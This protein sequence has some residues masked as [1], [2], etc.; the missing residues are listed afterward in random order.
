MKV[1]RHKLPFTTETGYTFNE[2]DIAYDTWGTLN[3]S[4][5]NVIWVCH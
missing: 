3:E 5:D 2:L 4:G 1:L